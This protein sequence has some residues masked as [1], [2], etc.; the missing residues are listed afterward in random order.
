MK[1]IA[2]RVT[3]IRHTR[4][5][6]SLFVELYDRIRNGYNNAVPFVIQERRI[7]LAQ[8]MTKPSQD[9][10]RYIP[11]TI[12]RHIEQS[13]NNEIH[14]EFNV[15]ERRI[16]LVFVVEDKEYKVSLYKKYAKSVA[17]WLHIVSNIHPICSKNLT[18]YFYMSL[19]AKQLPTEIDN[20]IAEQHANTGFTN[21]CSKSAEIV[22]Y[23]KEEWFKV[24]LH[25]T[26]HNFNMDFSAHDNGLAKRRMLSIFK[27]E[28]DVNLFEA[29]TETWAEIINVA[30]CS[31]AHSS[32]ETEYLD[33]AELLM[34]YERH[35]SRVQMSKVLRHI[36]TSYSQLFVPGNGY[37][38]ETNVLSYFV[39][40]CVL[41]NEH[42]Q[43][44]SWCK[45]NNS[46]DIFV[47]SADIGSFC[48][49]VGRNTNKR[50]LFVK[51]E[52]LDSALRMSIC[53]LS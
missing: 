25:E 51:E 27:V 10:F 6:D 52:S 14:I 19:L 32:S 16:R 46:A 44:M 42:Q 11:R 34:G 4:Q 43:F 1:S 30:F 45:T 7:K 53:E 37:R 22:I 8:E 18:V 33:N 40:K 39:I 48:D 15:G 9:K 5:T 36:G 21:N 35:Y 38:E 20:V 49:L 3:P 26:F 28:S 31:F 29:Y 41:L 47:F 50:N 2:P 23:R 17:A 12:A 24:F 13:S